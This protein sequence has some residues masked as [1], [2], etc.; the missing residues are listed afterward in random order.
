MEKGVF[1]LKECGVSDD[2]HQLARTVAMNFFEHGSEEEKASVITGIPGIRR[3]YSKLEAE[4]TAQVTN[5]GEYSDYSMC[6]SM[7]T[8]GNLFPSPEFKQVWTNYYNRMY[9][10]AQE[11]ARV[12]L[13]ATEA[14]CEGGIDSLLDCDPVL[15]FRYFPEV[16]EHRCAEFEPLRMAPHYDISIVTLIHQTP[17]PNGFVSLQYDVGGTFVDLPHVP[18]SVVVLCGAVATLVSGGKVKAPTHRVLAPTS[19]QRVGSSRTSSVFFL[20]PK[21][22]FTISIPLAK[23]CGLNISLTGDTALFKDWIGGNYINLHTKV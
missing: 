21:F 14:T 18:A 8:S 7:G 2:E 16:P 11:T 5:S 23:A 13:N 15:R 10:A 12:V 19:E 4:S 20:R 3:G 6:Y 1:Y 9:S 17:C 22:D